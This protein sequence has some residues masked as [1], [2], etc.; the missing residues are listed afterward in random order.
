MSN[1]SEAIRPQ[2]AEFYKSDPI[3]Q[4]EWRD[5]Q[6]KSKLIK[7]RIHQ[8]VKQLFVLLEK[9][10]DPRSFDEVEKAVI[11]LIFTLGR[12]FFAYFLAWRHENSEKDCRK[13]RGKYLEKGDAQP[14]TIG[15]YFGR[16]RYWRTYLRS[17]G[18]GG[19]EY[20]LD[21]ALRL[22]KDGFSM[23][24][25]GVCARLAVLMP[26]DR[27][28]QLL[29]TFMLWAP[30]K[31]TVEKAVLGLGRYTNDWFLEAPAPEGDGEVLVIQIDSK[32][33]PTATESELAKRRGKRRPNPH[34]DSARHRGRDKRQ[35]RGSKPRRKKGDKSKNGKAATLVV[36]YTLKS[37]TDDKGNPI[38]KGP[39]NRMAYASYAP[40][41]H[42]FAIARREADKRG[43][44]PESG[45]MIQLVTD[46]D[47]DLENY[48]REFFP[49][50]IHTLDIIHA[51]E[52]V[53]KAGRSLYRE[54]SDELASWAKRMK[55]LLYDGE[56]K[57]VVARIERCLDKIPKTG[58]GN[59]K[60][61]E[62]IEKAA[63]YLGKRV[64]MMNYDWLIDE[65]LE[66]ATGPVEGAVNY[67]IGTRFDNGGMRWIRER[68]EALLQLRCIEINGD[69]DRFTSFVQEKIAVK[70]M[71][72]LER[73]T[74]LTTE[75]SPLPTL[76]LT[77]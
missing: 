16:V 24:V 12:L 44:T 69:W 53:W 17:K 62:R 65:D 10:R 56:A 50:A 22:T 72:E 18:G 52:Y 34:S 26:F 75:E 23:L 2:V 25:M 43:F 73:Q 6:A 54:G 57:K 64:H 32:A 77:S 49:H 58:P 39:L 9:R 21:L 19:G 68:S 74:L 3:E 7:R 36:M 48:A 31:T 30:S 76:G 38:L 8:Q 51:M 40:K 59:K 29:V 15:T 28:T 45:K 55:D 60:K 33:T 46:G 66:I 1:Q 11:P 63:S 61:R 35:R 37:A 41:R 5:V 27:V 4:D 42:A 70:T 13:L 14:R 47:D 20:P 67:I 71:K